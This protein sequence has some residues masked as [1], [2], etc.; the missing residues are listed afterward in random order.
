MELEI[1]NEAQI[2]TTKTDLQAGKCFK[3]SSKR[4][5]F[6]INCK[7]MYM[8]IP[9]SLATIPDKDKQTNTAYAKS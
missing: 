4:K 1:S 3:V 7:L 5:N 9:E 6:K 8:F 2:T